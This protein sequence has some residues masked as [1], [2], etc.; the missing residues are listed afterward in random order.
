MQKEHRLNVRLSDD[1]MHKLEAQAEHM[2]RSVSVHVRELISE[3]ER[4]VMSGVYERLKD[5]QEGNQ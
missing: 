4:N 5:K 2:G 3:F 1:E